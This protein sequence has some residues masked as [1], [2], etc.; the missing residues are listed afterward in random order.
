MTYTNSEST[1]VFNLIVLLVELGKLHPQR[2]W[3]PRGQQGVHR[4]HGLCEGVD[5]LAGFPLKQRDALVP[6]V[7]VVGV[8]AQQHAVQQQGSP[9]QQVLYTGHPHLDVQLVC[10]GRE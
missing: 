8:L 9:L 10:W 3:T 4:L 2:V 5:D 6:L 7:H 1:H